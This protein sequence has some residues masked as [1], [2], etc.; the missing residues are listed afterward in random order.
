MTV[1]LRTEMHRSTVEDGVI[2]LGAIFLSTVTHLFNGFSE[3]IMS[4]SRL[5]VFYKQRD[6]L[7]YPAWAYALPTWLVKIPMSFIECAVWIGMTYYAIGFDPNVERFFRHYLLLVLISQMA[8]GLF[9]L[10]AALG[11]EMIVANTYGAF[12]QLVIL[13]LGGFLIDRGMFF[14]IQ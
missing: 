14:F 1:F 4:I 9:Q 3:L 5:P 13:I 11:R 6:M 2:F 8:S 10:S 7:L 12:A